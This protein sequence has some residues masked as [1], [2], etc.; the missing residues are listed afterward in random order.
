MTTQASQAKGSDAAAATTAQQQQQSGRR[1][2]KKPALI[3]L[4][5]A[6]ATAGITSLAIAEE[7]ADHGLH[8]PEFPWSHS[9]FFSAYD[10]ASIRRG[11]QVSIHGTD[12]P[13]VISQPSVSPDYPAWMI[14]ICCHLL[15]MLQDLQLH[16]LDTLWKLARKFIS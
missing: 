7:E 4:G 5:A 1:S 6:A 2:W 12:M 10:H 14:K 15:F 9:G 3:G 16:D 11:H 13:S 8:A